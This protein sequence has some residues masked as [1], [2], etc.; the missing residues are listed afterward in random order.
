[1]EE[2]SV[3]DWDIYD[4]GVPYNQG[5]TAVYPGAGY[6]AGKGRPLLRAM[7]YKEDGVPED[8]DDVMRFNLVK[9]KTELT[10]RLGPSG[11]ESNENVRE[12]KVERKVVAINLK[13]YSFGSEQCYALAEVLQ[14]NT[15][16][17]MLKIA[18]P[19]KMTEAEDSACSIIRAM[20]KNSS[21]LKL[22]L[23]KMKFGEAGADLLASMLRTNTVCL[24]LGLNECNLKYR[25]AEEIGLALRCNTTLKRLSVARNDL[26]SQG[27]EALVSFLEE[28]STLE[29]LNLF[30][31]G[32]TT[33]VVGKISGAL[34][35][36]A[37]I[38]LNELYLGCHK[39][40]G[41]AFQDLCSALQVCTTLKTLNL[42][43]SMLTDSKEDCER[44]LAMAL[45][46]GKC[47][48]TRLDLSRNSMSS[49][50]IEGIFSSL[51]KNSTLKHLNISANNFSEQM[52][53]VLFPPSRIARSCRQMLECNTTLESINLRTCLCGEEDTIEVLKAF[54]KNK[55]LRELRG[56]FLDGL[57]QSLLERLV[58]AP[59]L[60]PLML[61]D[62][63]VQL[64]KSWPFLVNAGLKISI[65][66]LQTRSNE[67]IA[68]AIHEMWHEKLL[69]F[70]MGHHKRLSGAQ[71]GGAVA[72]PV[73]LLGD[74]LVA[75]V[76]DMLFGMM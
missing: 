28:N 46:S 75:L 42:Y 29:S 69:A 10:A 61:D 63:D 30:K 11:D 22:D 59:R 33:D 66:D 31:T 49:E 45:G 36:N 60:V 68:Q 32:I 53:Q 24:E 25:E 72:S 35:S 38:C 8:E 3:L 52:S 34:R 27:G 12:Q 74:S 50:G 47:S 55:T 43:C 9:V 67:D 1:M 71:G 21:I 62:N 56:S 19:K 51:T 64:A 15:T 41:R 26:Q 6:Y 16:I 40:E 54:P 13:G 20:G 76:G 39:F 48:L 70:A 2:K 4:L 44:H 57:H 65:P 17:E 37:N 18:P 23:E 58:A 5:S 14:V 73:Y 7:F